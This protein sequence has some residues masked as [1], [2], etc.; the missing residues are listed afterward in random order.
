MCKLWHLMQSLPALWIRV[1]TSGTCRDAVHQSGFLLLQTS[2][3]LEDEKLPERRTE[4]FFTF[5][6]SRQA[7]LQRPGRSCL[8]IFPNKKKV[9]RVL[10]YVENMRQYKK[11]LFF[12]GGRISIETKDLQNSPFPARSR[13]NSG[14]KTVHKSRLQLFSVILFLGVSSCDRLPLRSSRWAAVTVTA[15]FIHTFFQ[16]FQVTIVGY[17]HL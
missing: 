1:P 15:S 12:H 10:E 11:M 9:W 13:M 3:N 8:A 5:A 16:D 7:K 6:V 17:L 14:N 4:L 2:D